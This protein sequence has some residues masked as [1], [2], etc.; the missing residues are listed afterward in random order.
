MRLTGT[1]SK[2][3]PLIRAGLDGRGGSEVMVASRPPSAT[4]RIA[5][6]APPGAV[7]AAAATPRPE[8]SAR[9]EFAYC[10]VDGLTS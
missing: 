6:A 3:D 5:V 2:A 4:A 7:L 1:G 10:I 8:V 9:T